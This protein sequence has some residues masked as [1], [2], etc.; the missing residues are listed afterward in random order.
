MRS[1]EPYSPTS[2]DATS[3]EDYRL[4]LSVVKS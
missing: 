4:R 3:L 1:L 2:D